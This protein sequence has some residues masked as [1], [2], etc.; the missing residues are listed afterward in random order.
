MHS[1][2]NNKYTP[3]SFFSTL[4]VFSF[5]HVIL[6]YSSIEFLISIVPCIN[7]IVCCCCCRRPGKYALLMKPRLLLYAMLGVPARQSHTA[8]LLALG[9]SEGVHCPWDH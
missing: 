3:P 5:P 9:S 8:G 6:L 7:I 1:N 4:R 2:N